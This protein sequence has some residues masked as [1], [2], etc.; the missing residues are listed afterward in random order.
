MSEAPG[1]FLSQDEIGVRAE[2]GQH[3]RLSR[4]RY[5]LSRQRRL[6]SLEGLFLSVIEDFIATIV[7]QHPHERHQQR[8]QVAC[9]TL[10]AS[11]LQGV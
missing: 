11:D 6:H 2:W 7:T 4:Q 8:V 5:P 9:G 3:R 1:G 10:T